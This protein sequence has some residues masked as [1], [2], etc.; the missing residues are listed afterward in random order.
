MRILNNV[1]ELAAYVETL[2]DYEAGFSE[3]AADAN[4]ISQPRHRNGHTFE[5][6]AEARDRAARAYSKVEDD[7]P[8][9]PPYF[10]GYTDAADM[11]ALCVRGDIP[12]RALQLKGA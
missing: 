3:G 2:F 11:V 7:G 9:A 8:D 1:A 12:N 10:H 6:Y 5:A 4:L